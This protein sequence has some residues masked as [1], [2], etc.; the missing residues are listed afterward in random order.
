MA[1]VVVRPAEAGDLPGLMDLF[2]E[3]ERMQRDWR[4][5]PLRPTFRL[6]TEAS[7]RSSLADP[8]A[9]LLIALD[10]E[11]VVGGALGHVHKPSSFSDEL[12]VELSS[13]VVQPSHR[14]RGIAGALVAAVARFAA[15]RGLRRVTLKTF[16]QNV[17]ALAY[18]E[19]MGFRAR[20]IQMTAEALA[21]A[22]DPA[23]LEKERGA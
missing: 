13:V 6:E 1:E 7:F 18:W 14:N 2:G 5:F 21:L 16:A 3:L 20:V 23:E 15:E 8:N 10:G 11:R 22:G 12:A 4:V 17:Q 9:L 19:R